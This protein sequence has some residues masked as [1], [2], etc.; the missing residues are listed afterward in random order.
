MTTSALDS[1]QMLALVRDAN[2]GAGLISGEAVRWGRGGGCGPATS[3]ATMSHPGRR[4]VDRCTSPPGGGVKIGAGAAA[5]AGSGSLGWA[6]ASAATGSGAGS[7]TS[8]TAAATGSGATPTGSTAS[9]TEGSGA[10]GSGAA[11]TSATAAAGSGAMTGSGAS[12]GW[13]W[14]AW[15]ADAASR[16]SSSE[17]ARTGASGST[18]SH[19]GTVSAGV[20]SGS[21]TW[22]AAARRDGGLGLDGRRRLRGGCAILSG[23]VERGGLVELGRRRDGVPGRQGEGGLH[24]PGLDGRR[25]DG[26]GSQQRVQAAQRSGLRLQRRAHGR[27]DPARPGGAAQ[28]ATLGVVPAIAAGVLPAVHAEVEGLME[29][30]ELERGAL[31]VLITFALREGRLQRIVGEDE[32][33]QTAREDPGLLDARPAGLRLSRLEGVTGAATFTEGFGQELGHDPQAVRR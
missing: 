9:A 4:V 14:A 1:S 19:S 12:A 17:G 6:G 21:S 8:S 28:A 10:A 3:G 2:H 25:R 24:G 32:V 11:S 7:S 22:V 5:G 33:L 29:G 30:L 20:S 18:A 15:A 13:A 26:T 16:Y 27:L 23:G 31:A